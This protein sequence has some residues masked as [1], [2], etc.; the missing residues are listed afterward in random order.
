M[1]WKISTKKK[2]GGGIYYEKRERQKI[3]HLSFVLGAI[4]L[5]ISLLFTTPT[6]AS[7]STET[8]NSKTIPST[9]KDITATEPSTTELQ[10]PKNFVSPSESLQGSRN[11][12]S[13]SENNIISELM[14]SGLQY[15]TFGATSF[16]SYVWVR[17]GYVFPY[18][19]FIDAEVASGTAHIAYEYYD[20]NGKFLYRDERKGSGWLVA[21]PER[22][23][24]KIKIVNLGSSKVTLK[25]GNVGYYN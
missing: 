21:N 13:S 8:Q 12:S 1:H 17:G 3:K 25:Y 15:Y 5:S 16:Q 10:G 22:G 19:Q 23:P 14:S 2:L 11:S 4:T 9:I 7:A 18:V 6:P 20:Q 24:M